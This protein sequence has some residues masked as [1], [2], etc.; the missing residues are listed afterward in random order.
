MQQ[1]LQQ[2]QHQIATLSAG[3]MQ[4]E[5]R[6]RARDRRNGGSRSSSGPARRSSDA[7]CESPPSSDGATDDGSGHDESGIR[8]GHVRCPICG[9]FTPGYD[10]HC[11]WLDLCVGSHNIGAFFRGLLLLLGPRSGRLDTGIAPNRLPSSL[12]QSNKKNFENFAQRQDV[13]SYRVTLL[14]LGACSSP[15]APPPH[16]TEAGQYR[17]ETRPRQ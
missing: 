5:R 4:M 10:H 14:S 7:R 15:L 3:S 17:I 13:G 11:V 6:Q 16:E 12:T 9:R 1:H 2:L 8:D